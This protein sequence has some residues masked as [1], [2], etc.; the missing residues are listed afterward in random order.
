M[1]LTTNNI[2]LIRSTNEEAGTWAEL[3][4]FRN[5]VL[6]KAWVVSER[7]EVRARRKAE[8]S[9]RER[10]AK[11]E[12]KKRRIREQGERKH[13]TQKDKKRDLAGGG[14]AREKKGVTGDAH[15]PQRRPETATV[16][17]APERTVAMPKVSRPLGK[18]DA[19]GL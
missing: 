13:S 3:S 16:V 2:A 19:L 14:F 8:G 10:K 7:D 18:F 17:E 11:E 15:Q 6:N 1:I 5:D 9:Y 12:R 4:A